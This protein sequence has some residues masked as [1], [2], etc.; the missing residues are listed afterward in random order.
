MLQLKKMKIYF[1]LGLLIFLSGCQ[2]LPTTLVAKLMD[3]QQTR[4][5][6]QYL[7]QYAKENINQRLIVKTDLYYGDLPSQKLDIIYPEI[8]V[9]KKIP[10]I[11][12]VHGGGWVAGNKESMLPYAKLLA[13]RGFLVVNVEYTLVPQAAYPQQVLELNQAVGYIVQHQNQLPIDL[14]RIFFSGDSAGANITSSYIAAL[15]ATKMSEQLNLKASISAQSVRGLVLHSGVYDLKTLYHSS[16]KAGKIVSWGAQSVI[17]QYSG[18]SRPTDQQLDLMSA[19]P[20]IT[21]QFPPVYISATD[22]DILTQTQTK[23]FVKKLK[24]LGV[25]V[26][27]KIYGKDYAENINH[28]FNFNMRFKASHEVFDQSIQFLKRHS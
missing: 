26:S 18:Y 19:Y 21:A 15:N 25:V 20:W 7:E 8:L 4:E 11:F 9:D 1:S 10:V 16:A 2:N 12:L 6:V 24:N 17:A 14:S 13:D 22:Q 3:N 5:N 27:S 28:D 23:P